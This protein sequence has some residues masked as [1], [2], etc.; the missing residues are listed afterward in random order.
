MEAK[1]V[2]TSCGART[3]AGHPCRNFKGYKTTHP[4]E[5]RCFLHGGAQAN[6]KRKTA[7]GI[8]AVGENTRLQARIERHN[9]AGGDILDLRPELALA[10][11][12]LEEW[13]EDYPVL[14]TQ[15]SDWHESYVG[16]FR[17]EMN[18]LRAAL[19]GSDPNAAEQSLARLRDIIHAMPPKPPRVPDLIDA[20]KVLE[21]VGRLVDRITQVRERQMV[22]LGAV[23]ELQQRMAQ[24]MTAH[25]LRDTK[26]Q[27]AARKLSEKIADAWLDVQV[28][29]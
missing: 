14:R 13:V 5:G 8:Y 7:G 17:T 20:T 18:S 26:D 19:N 24:V 25:M 29:Y 10:R 27:K 28:D 12:I 15:L 22:P 16:I 9:K 11:A 2:D 23:M 1:G 3:Q 4:G 21:Q 6:D